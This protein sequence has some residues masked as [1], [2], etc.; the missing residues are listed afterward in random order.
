M[1]RKLPQVQ[2][3]RETKILDAKKNIEIKLLAVT[4]PRREVEDVKLTNEE[5]LTNYHNINK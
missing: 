4:F 3:R 2:M 1:R 5:V